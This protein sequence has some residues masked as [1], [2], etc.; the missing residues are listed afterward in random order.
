[1]RASPRRWHDAVI[2]NEVLDRPTRPRNI[3]VHKSLL[4]VPHRTLPDYVLLAMWIAALVDLAQQ[5]AAC[6]DEANQ[7]SRLIAD[8]ALVSQQIFSHGQSTLLAVFYE[9]PLDGRQLIGRIPDR[10]RTSTPRPMRCPNSLSPEVSFSWLERAFALTHDHFRSTLYAN[11]QQHY[12]PTIS[13]G[14]NR[15]IADL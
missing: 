3:I 9:C 14:I 8:A 11:G 10:D 12:I 6:E 4:N 13:K 1:V 7:G 5:A 2:S 15:Y